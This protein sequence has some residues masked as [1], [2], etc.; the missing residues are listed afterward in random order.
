MIKL[1]PQLNTEPAHKPI[2]DAI[3][4]ALEGAEFGYSLQLTRLVDGESTYTL[5]YT[6]GSEPIEFDDI[7]AGYAHVAEK[8]RLV[9][10]LAVLTAMVRFGWQVGEIQ[11]PNTD[12]YPFIVQGGVLRSYP[13][14]VEFLNQRIERLTDTD[15]RVVAAEVRAIAAEK[16]G[17]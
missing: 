5:K 4:Q 12:G 14:T 9:Q 2:V 15:P 3:A 17:A 8:K 7:D 11:P 10:A 13:E 6:D 16:R 1:T